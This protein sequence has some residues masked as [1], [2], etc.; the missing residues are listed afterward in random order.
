MKMCIAAVISGDISSKKKIKYFF[1][2]SI[3]SSEKNNKKSV[4]LSNALHNDQ[5]AEISMEI[6]NKGY[7]LRHRMAGSYIYFFWC[8]SKRYGKNHI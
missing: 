8:K 1:L 5:S 3:I 4:L 2:S 7:E 6:Y